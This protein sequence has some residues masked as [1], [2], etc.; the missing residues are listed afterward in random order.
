MGSPLGI[1]PRGERGWGRNA[2]RKRSWGSPRGSFFVAGTGMGSYSPAG[3]SPLPSLLL[4]LNP[5]RWRTAS[6]A[7][8]TPCCP[9]VSPAA[10]TP[11]SHPGRSST[12]KLR[13]VRLYLSSFSC[14]RHRGPRRRALGLG[15]H[16]A[17]GGQGVARA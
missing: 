11:S 7:A 2:P 14:A 6:M 3:N 16:A 13:D 15:D 8:A 9:S 10:A 5:P 12:S 1:Y 4:S 17:A